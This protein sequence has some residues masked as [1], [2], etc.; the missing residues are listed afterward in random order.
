MYSDFVDGDDEQDHDP[1][2]PKLRA[3][4]AL[5]HTVLGTHACLLA[6]VLLLHLTWKNGSES[7]DK[8]LGVLLL[9]GG[10]LWL[11]SLGLAVLALCL[12]TQTGAAIAGNGM[13]LPPLP[14]ADEVAH[15]RRRRR[16]AVM[17]LLFNIVLMAGGIILIIHGAG[18][19]R[20]YDGMAMVLFGYLGLAASWLCI[21]GIFYWHYSSKHGQ[22][23]AINPTLLIFM[24]LSVLPTLPELLIGVI[25]LLFAR[26]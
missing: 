11:L 24:L 26:T 21:A 3:M 6:A 23:A 10:L 5:F 13:E 4:H 20:H 25:Q 15:A 9:A 19:D 17:A 1:R 16:Q 18:Q 7:L 22:E 2:S 8:L 14:G 12:R